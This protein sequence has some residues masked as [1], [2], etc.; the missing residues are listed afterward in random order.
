MKKLLCSLLM[1][2]GL[3]AVGTGCS[4][5]KKIDLAYVEKTFETASADLKAE[6]TKIADEV[7]AQK[8]E[9]ALKGAQALMAK[10]TLTPEEDAA[11]QNLVA[12]LEAFVKK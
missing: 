12:E 11:I 3:V 7:R 9:D 8:H 10:G 2:I 1:A 4:G 6:V 5:G